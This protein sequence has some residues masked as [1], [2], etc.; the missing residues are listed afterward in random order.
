MT[1][2]NL[3]SNCHVDCEIGT[4]SV[5]TL[6]ARRATRSTPIEKLFYKLDTR[7]KVYHYPKFQLKP[8]CRFRDL[9]IWH[10]NVRRAARHTEYPDRK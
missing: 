5:K 3:S 9:D 2:S 8:P 4:Y 10:Y 1:V 6:G 7:I